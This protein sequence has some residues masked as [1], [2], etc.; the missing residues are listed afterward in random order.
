MPGVPTVRD[1]VAATEGALVSTDRRSGPRRTL[2]LLRCGPHVLGIE[3]AQ[4]HTTLAGTGVR[5][6]VLSSTLCQGVTEYRDREVPVVDPLMLL[7]LGQLRVEDAPAGLVL[8]LDAGFVVLALTAVLDI[9][10]V[11]EADILPLPAMSLRRPGLFAGIADVDGV[12]QCLVLDGTAVLAEPDLQAFAAVNIT[13]D[14][15]AELTGPTGATGA[16]I[17]P[18]ATAAGAGTGTA[19]APG[20][21]T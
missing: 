12:G 21:P 7:G 9:L 6:S 10:E 13:L 8:K 1:D 3:V 15:A 20:G 16:D 2:T 5:P 14:A 11:A 4:V 19:P 18:S 17:D